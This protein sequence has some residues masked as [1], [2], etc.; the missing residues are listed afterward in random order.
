MGPLFQTGVGVRDGVD[1]ICVIG[2]IKVIGV[3]GVINVIK[4]IGVIGVIGVISDD[5]LLNDGDVVTG[6][7]ELALVKGLVSQV[8]D[9]W[10]IRQPL[11]QVLYRKKASLK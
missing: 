6:G 9:H 5:F 4:V 11:I 7:G 8:G 3:I 2:V 1:V 10:T